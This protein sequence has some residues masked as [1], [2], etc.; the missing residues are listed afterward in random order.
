M[1]SRCL[2]CTHY[3]ELPEPLSSK[4]LTY[5]GMCAEPSRVLMGQTTLCAPTIGFALMCR[6][7]EE[8]VEKEE[9]A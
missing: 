9:A 7:H 5:T 8:K 2:T 3:R 1:T 6:F 4:T